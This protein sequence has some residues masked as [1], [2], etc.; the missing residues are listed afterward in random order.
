MRLRNGV[1]YYGYRNGRY[2]YWDLKRFAVGVLKVVA[3]CIFIGLF[4]HFI[5][6]DSLQ[7]LDIGF[8]RG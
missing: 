6:G 3:A 2:K 8:Y 4:N 7:G 5:G 1:L